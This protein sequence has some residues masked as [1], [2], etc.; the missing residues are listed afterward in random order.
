MMETPRPDLKPLMDAAKMT[1]A[2]IMLA[3]AYITD[4]LDKLYDMGA[5]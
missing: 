4:L 2:Q 3:E 1:R 5:R